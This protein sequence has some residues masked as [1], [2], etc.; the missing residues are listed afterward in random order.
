MFDCGGKGLFSWLNAHTFS[1]ATN[2]AEEYAVQIFKSTPLEQRKELLD[3]LMSTSNKLLKNL[4][5]ETSGLDGLQ[6]ALVATDIYNWMHDLGYNKITDDQALAAG[7]AHKLWEYRAE[8][9]L[10]SAS[11][12]TFYQPYAYFN[13]AGDKIMYMVPS[14]R[15]QFSCPSCSDSDQPLRKYA[16]LN[17]WVAVYAE[18]NISDLGLSKGNLPLYRLFTCIGF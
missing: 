18:E 3:S 6:S 2:C 1:I 7:Y 17:Q 12:T 13:D 11:S 5:A 10:S 8:S 16:D 4:F 15:G 14:A 9:V